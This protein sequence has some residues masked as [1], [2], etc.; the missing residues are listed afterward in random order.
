MFLIKI[1]KIPKKEGRHTAFIKL[2][3]AQVSVQEEVEG[4][5]KAVTNCEIIQANRYAPLICG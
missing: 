3:I 2:G 5:F 4:S 1:Y